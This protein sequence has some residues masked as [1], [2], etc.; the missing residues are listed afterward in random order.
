MSS[1]SD[2]NSPMQS[3]S[4]TRL[5]PGRRRVLDGLLGEL[6]DLAPPEREAR[7]ESFSSR[8]PRLHHW[9]AR[10]LRA[11]TTPTEYL[12]SPFGRIAGE[13]MASRTPRESHLPH[14]T[15]LGP[16]R[17]LEPVGVGGMGMV[18]RAERA[19]E[20]FDMEVAVKLIRVR[21]DKSLEARLTLERQLLARLDHPNIA[22]LLDGGTTED[23][24][25]YLVM[26]WVPGEDLSERAVRIRASENECLDVFERIAAAVGHAHQRRVV[27]GDIKPANVRITPEGRARLLDFGVARLL[28]GEGEAI[29]G[30]LTALTPAFSAP[31]Q[32]EGEPASTQSDIWALGAL[33]YWLL[34]GNLRRRNA[35][36]DAREL[37]RD[38]ASIVDRACAE[39]PT[40][41]YAG[42][43]ELLGD[44]GRYRNHQPV[45]ARRA[46]RRYVLGRFVR[47]NPVGVGLGMLS[48]LMLLVGLA[49]TAWQAHVAGL[50][51]DRAQLEA[52]RT[53]RVSDFLVDL[54]EQADPYR[55]SGEEITARDLV[56]RGAE[57]IE[58]LD[59]TPL[60]QAEMYR[61]LA[62]V[63]RALGEYDNAEL[64]LRRALEITGTAGPAVTIEE[65]IGLRTQ[66]GLVLQDLGRLH[67]ARDVQ[68]RALASLPENAGVI[69]E[70]GVRNNLGSVLR[71]QGEFERSEALLRESLALI[72]GDERYDGARATTLNNLA[73]LLTA[74]GRDAEARDLFVEALELSRRTHGEDHSLTS[75]LVGNLANTHVALGD[76]DA[77]AGA[78]REALD[79]RLRIL[80]DDH[81]DVAI[82]YHQI[83]IA[84]LRAQDPEGAKPWLRKAVAVRAHGLPED[85]PALGRS[86]NALAGALRETDNLGE[87]GEMVERALENARL[88]VGE[89]HPSYAAVL[90]HLAVVRMDQGD[91]EASERLH[92]KALG[93]R[94]AAFGEQHNHVANSFRGLARL[95]L[96]QGQH[97]RALE[98]ARKAL[99]VHRALYESSG[100]PE[101]NA[102][103]ELVAEIEAA[104]SRSGNR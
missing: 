49:G 50:E 57:R 18:Y 8:Y 2:S 83:G 70:S 63:N 6:L 71:E 22:R 69:L 68:E 59:E 35:N 30:S 95:H 60:I 21:H 74:L 72:E 66:L 34:T 36:G 11:S 89:A 102:S 51:R 47:R 67:E 91:V 98:Y 41:R 75:T 9:L 62:E 96:V 100:H 52:D 16:W 17:L 80:D 77:A 19:D 64:M 101:V 104:A 44:I 88:S 97:E 4:G 86:L 5:T 76:Y 31:E 85:H 92:H 90:A 7:L 28:A 43:S 10:L 27:H 15:R 26:E 3:E 81:P 54:F 55:A 48:L 103:D 78:Y 13:A 25:T 24:Q 1:R 29:E 14:G 94:R 20:A 99:A 33:L 61:V 40:A 65:V 79:A 73:G 39:A 32:L 84:R 45:Q 46:T 87:A 42:V 53:A 23:G 12:Q 56:H 58:S 37:G 93:I 38:L 82:F